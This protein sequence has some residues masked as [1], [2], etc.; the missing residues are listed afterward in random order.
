MRKVIFIALIFG[1]FGMAVW[2]I[3]DLPQKAPEKV[4]GLSFVAP[5]DSF[6]SDV[7]DPIL[8][9]N[10]NFG[11][12]IPYAFMRTI[13]SDSLF[14]NRQRQWW[15][16]RPVGAK[17]NL[18]LFNANGIKTMLKPQIWIGRGAYTGDINFNTE[19]E[20][21]AFEKAYSEYI[22]DFAKIAAE[23]QADL[24]CIGTEL[25][26]FVRNRPDYWQQLIL[27]IR[28]IYPGQLTY[29]ANW[30][31]YKSVSFWEQLDYIGIDAYFPLS[32]KKHPDRATLKNA[33][34]RIKSTLNYWSNQ[35]N[36]PI[37]FTEYGYI[38]ADY[39]A[40]EPWKNA[41]DSIA[42]NLKLQAELYEALYENLW[43]E[44]WFAGGFFWKW[45]SETGRRSLIKRFTPQEK[46]ALEV[47]KHYYNYHKT[48]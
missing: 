13:D 7:I 45:H 22:L 15:G 35:H 30:D 1:I 21:L 5:R 47:I 37:L 10:A 32:D 6:S 2:G 46:P 31:E 36:K 20:W 43:S 38:S 28:K 3:A 17:H 27:E 41:H 14:Y 16:E 40:R 42:V 29:A 19:R 9:T 12:V 23:E 18:K 4:N 11:A 34:D 39:A 26:N 44:D 8:A 24:F 33:W 25:H 48:E